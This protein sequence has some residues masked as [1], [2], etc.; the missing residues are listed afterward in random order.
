MTAG[1]RIALYGEVRNLTPNVQ[2]IEL[3]LPQN[4]R[5]SPQPLY[6]GIFDTLRKASVLLKPFMIQTTICPH[7]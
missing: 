1:Q 4:K 3:W 6:T 2:H 7:I 5:S